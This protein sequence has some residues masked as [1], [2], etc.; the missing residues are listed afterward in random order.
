MTTIINTPRGS[1]DSDGSGIG[2]LLGI[3]VTLIVGGLIV[4]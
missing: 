4:Y 1:S 3:I 2:L